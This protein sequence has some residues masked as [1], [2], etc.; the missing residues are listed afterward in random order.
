M[1]Y[2]QYLENLQNAY[3]GIGFFIQS[4]GLLR[5][6]AWGFIFILIVAFV[7]FAHD[8][9]DEGYGTFEDAKP[10]VKKKIIII[11]ILMLV[12]S[13]NSFNVLSRVHSVNNE[14]KDLMENTTTIIHEVNFIEINTLG[15]RD[16]VTTNQRRRF[17]ILVRYDENLYVRETI[18]THLR[19]SINRNQTSSHSINVSFD[20]ID[21]GIL[22]VERT[23]YNHI[24]ERFYLHNRLN[25]CPTIKIYLIL[26]IQYANID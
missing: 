25:K 5:F 10:H 2:E 13:I 18:E 9:S 11:Y 17:E 20:V 26:P 23:Y 6:F 1:T 12:I 4:I 7:W 19:H 21:E 15:V 8:M 3:W 16:I 14:V 22:R 24:D